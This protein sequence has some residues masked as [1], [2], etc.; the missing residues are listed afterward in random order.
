MCTLSYSQQ[1]KLLI[2]TYKEFYL[3]ADSK[4]VVER[5]SSLTRGGFFSIRV[6]PSFE[7]EGLI[8][9]ILLEQ[10]YSGLFPTQVTRGEKFLD[11]RFADGDQGLWG[12]EL[13]R[14]EPILEK[15][16]SVIVEKTFLSKHRFFT[17][18]KKIGHFWLA[19]ENGQKRIVFVN[20]GALNLL[21]AKDEEIAFHEH[22][23][24][25]NRDWKVK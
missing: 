22:F 1:K 10:E 5:H 8:L 23:L 6:H 4:D 15:P 2:E 12:P 19:I 24:E 14:C 13:I 9:R 18:V 21:F 17:L 11:W 25:N 3:G 20:D 16:G 7:K